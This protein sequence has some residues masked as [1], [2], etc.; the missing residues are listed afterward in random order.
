[1][2]ELVRPMTPEEERK[3]EEMIHEYQT[4]LDSDFEEDTKEFETTE[5]EL[6]ELRKHE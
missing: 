1:M 2:S 4:V 3:Q 5:E 6:E